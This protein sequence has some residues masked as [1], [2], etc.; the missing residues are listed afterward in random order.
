MPN[1]IDRSI[2]EQ[3][4]RFMLQQ[5]LS[6]FTSPADAVTEATR[7]LAERLRPASVTR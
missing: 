4:L 7:R 6:G 2:V 3:E 1:S 5:V